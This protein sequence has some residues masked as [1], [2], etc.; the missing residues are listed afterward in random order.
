MSD[1]N[2]QNIGSTIE[3]LSTDLQA[4][5][6]R[7]GQA[8][9]SLAD[10]YRALVRLV[11]SHASALVDEAGKLRPGVLDNITRIAPNVDRSTFSSAWGAFK[12]DPEAFA[13]ASAVRRFSQ[14]VKEHR[15]GGADKAAQNDLARALE[16]AAEAIR[17]A[18]EAG[19]SAA[20]L[21]DLIRAAYKPAAKPAETPKP[22]EAQADATQA[23]KAA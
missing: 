23:R 11:D 10:A 3:T 13:E 8:Q 2:I 21:A 14:I 4:I 6:T 12:A 17:K 18:A 15:A 9:T 22:A 16:R 19:V 7:I 20:T 1:Q 5:N